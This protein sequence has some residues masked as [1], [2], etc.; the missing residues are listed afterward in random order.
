VSDAPLK[1]SLVTPSY[2]QGQFLEATIQSVLGQNYPALEYFVMDGGSKDESPAIIQ[3]HAAQ[4][5]G[6][7]SE[8]DGGQ[9][10][11]VSKG[12]ARS[13][14]EVMGWLNSDD[15]L[16][17][18]AL[19]VV[20]EIFA[21]HPEI[22]WLTS[23][24]PL[25]FDALG[26]AVRCLPQ[27]G[28]SKAGFFAGEYLQRA[29]HFSTGHIQQES[30]FWRRSLWERA[31]GFVGGDYPL[32]GDFE[33]WARFFQHAELYGVE[34]PLGG[35][36]YHGNQKT[37]SQLERYYEEAERALLAHGGRR[38]SPVGRFFRQHSQQSC[39]R[40][41]R[42]FAARAGLVHPVKIVRQRRDTGEWR[43]HQDWN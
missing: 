28:F 39:P 32:A 40:A 10:E 11:A 1:I 22:E 41:L 30:T 19:S 18:W 33:L 20:G 14:G 23:L 42:S 26:R 38:P 37:G 5:A 31:G 2:Q 16:T 43:I 7:A 13:T 24:A 35:F 6:F 29:G 12:L 8:P 15:L 9:Y 3:R 25:R 21:A 36:R 34:T 27:R 17:P 4:L